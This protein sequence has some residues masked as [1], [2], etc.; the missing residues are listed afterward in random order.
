MPQP[1]AGAIAGCTAAVSAP[2]HSLAFI[3][4]EQHNDVKT[5]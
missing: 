5:L 3:A 4:G 2:W 1:A